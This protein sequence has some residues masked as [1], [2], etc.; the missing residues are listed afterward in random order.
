MNT[1][2]E[3]ILKKSGFISLAQLNALRYLDFNVDVFLRRAKESGYY[4]NS[5]F[6]FFGDHNTSMNPTENFKK[7]FDLEIQVHHVPFFIYVPPKK[8]NA[9]KRFLIK[10]TS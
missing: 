7:E 5:V 2:S 4:D 8:P 3:D 6:V 10:T 1:I 9:Q